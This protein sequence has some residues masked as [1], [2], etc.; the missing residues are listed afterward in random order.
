M[1]RWMQGL[2]IVLGSFVATVAVLA[3]AL[4]WGPHH[5]EP[6]FPMVIGCAMGSY[7]SLAGGMIAA[8]AALVA[9][10]LAW[11]AVQLQIEAEEKRGAADRAE[12]EKVL[13]G[14]LDYLGEALAAIWKILEGLDETITPKARRERLEGVV[15]GIKR[16]TK[17]T[18]LST[19]RKMVTVLGWERRRSYEELFDGLDRLGR[20]RQA[21]DFDVDMA[22]NA[23]RGVSND[24]ELLRPDTAQYF[25]GL[26]R[27]TPKAWT[28]G[29]AIQVQ[30][31]VNK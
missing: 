24:F 16:I 25:E 3:G 31:G 5:C 1:K 20:F 15:Y 30:A 19:S 14:D 9:G 6:A 28:L 8:G 23:V 7:E 18:W 10:W 17:E 21:V 2:C 29:Y 12:V 22:L 11:S 26:F 13:Q 27:R 4:A